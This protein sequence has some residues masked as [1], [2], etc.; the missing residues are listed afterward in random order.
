MRYLSG[1]LLGVFLFASLATAG[2]NAEAIYVKSC[3]GCHGAGGEKLA[4]GSE[5]PIKGMTL[6]ELK[7]SLAGY[8]SGTYGGPKKSI[9]E[10]VMKRLSDEEVEALAEYTASF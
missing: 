2:G 1:V 5:R 6:E 9:M 3:K 8:K 4:P 10:R 7:S